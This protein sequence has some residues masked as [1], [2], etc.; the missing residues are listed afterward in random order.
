[1][2]HTLDVADQQALAKFETIIDVR[3][4]GEFAEDHVPGAINLPV[5]NDE[6]RGVVGTIYVQ[7]SRFEARRLGAAIVAR[8]IAYHLEG[9][10]STKTPA[11]APLVYCWRGG[12]RSSAMATILDQV[13]WRPTLLAGGYKTYRREICARLNEALP[14]IVLLGG[15]TGTAKTA[16]LSEAKTLGAQVLDLEGLAHHRGSLL[17]D[18]AGKAQPSQKMFE[19]RLVIELAAL[20]PSRPVLMEAESSKIGDINIPDA[21]WKAMRSAPMIEVRAP[22][23]A[24][25]RYLLTEYRD[26]TSDPD[27][28]AFA[29]GRLPG[30]HG[31]ACLEGWVKLADDGEHE[32]LAVALMEAH[33]DPAYTRWSRSHP[34]PCL[35]SLELDNLLEATVLDTAARIVRLLESLELR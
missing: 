20:D 21:L 24:R 10:L 9:A 35:E 1:V 4:P 8:N 14:P 6:E 5:L 32:A 13:G 15:H 27:R 17:G 22:I 7:K 23:P 16:M 26:L 33:Y 2:I 29:L 30:R 3:S 12:Q 28:L 34:R 19:S 25:A 18:I 11:F 31:R